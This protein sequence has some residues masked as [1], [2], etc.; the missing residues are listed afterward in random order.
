MPVNRS[1]LLTAFL[2]IA[3]FLLPSP[4]AGQHTM[5]QAGSSSV[6]K[7]IA[8]LYPTKGSPVKGTV[9][10]EAV[11]NGIHVVADITGLTPGKH[12]I[13]IHEFGDCSAPDAFSAGGHFNPHVTAHGSPEGKPR[14]AGDMGNLVADKDGHARLDYVDQV[15]VFS[16]DQSIL[17]HAVIVHEQEDDLKSQP[18]GNAGARVACGVIGVAKGK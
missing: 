17:G 7:A 8:V 2:F 10:F 9:T 14:H 15:M 13:H 11:E 16:G 18:T 4:A 3:L 12:G 6:T 1:L 5:H